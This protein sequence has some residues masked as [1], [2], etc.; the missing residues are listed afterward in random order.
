MAIS[1]VQISLGEKNWYGLG[2]IS[3]APNKQG[4]GIGSLL[5]NSSLEKLKKSGAKGCVVLGDPK[6]YSRFGFK[7]SPDLKLAGVT[8]E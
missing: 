2:P 1:P 8:P 4:H 5:I 7:E 3:V 6:Y